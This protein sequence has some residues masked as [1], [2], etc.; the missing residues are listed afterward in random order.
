VFSSHNLTPRTIT[1]VA[2]VALKVFIVKQEGLDKEDTLVSSSHFPSSTF[3]DLNDS[4]NNDVCL[5]VS[6]DMNVFW[7]IH[8]L[9]FGCVPC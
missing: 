3:I 1:F 7:L 8:G 2:N 6:F 9:D 4:S 5:H